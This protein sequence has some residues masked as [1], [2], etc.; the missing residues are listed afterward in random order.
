MRGL[1]SK[2]NQASC[3]VRFNQRYCPAHLRQAPFVPC[4]LEALVPVRGL[5]SPE[6]PQP[7]QLLHLSGG[8]LPGEE[9]AGAQ[10]THGGQQ[11]Q[12]T[13][14]PGPRSWRHPQQVDRKLLRG[15]RR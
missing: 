11:A 13:E 5:V 12:G 9:H 6:A 8:R 1:L 14:Q 7:A 15:F 3:C 10:R 4:P 2:T